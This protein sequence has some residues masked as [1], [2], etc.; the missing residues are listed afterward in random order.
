MR[1]LHARIL[2]VTWALASLPAIAQESTDATHAAPSPDAV[3]WVRIDGR[4]VIGLRGIPTYPAQRRAAEVKGRILAVAND[5]AT[6]PA[7]ARGA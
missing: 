1:C 3:S 2:L 6:D 7:T 4:P 5:P